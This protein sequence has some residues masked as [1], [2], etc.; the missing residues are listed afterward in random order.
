MRAILLAGGK[1][2]RLYPYTV[3]LPKP[4]VPIEDLPIVEILLRQLARCG[5]RDITVSTGHLAEIMVAFLG[6]GSRFGV[7]IDYVREDMPLGTV[8]PL[9][10]V[11]ELPEQFLLMNGDVL[12]DL[13]YSRLFDDHV[14]GGAEVTVAT[15][16][17]KIPIDLGVIES[18]GRAITG[19]R[20][21]PTLTY[22]VS[23]GVYAIKRGALDLIPEG[24]VL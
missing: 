8:G 6:D 22:D 15:Y 4:L 7:K 21:K 3:S 13:D 20:E 24:K 10:L 2:T 18:S 17:K 23:M 12:T 14:R 9:K 5:I 11:R 16:S 1:G 19:Y